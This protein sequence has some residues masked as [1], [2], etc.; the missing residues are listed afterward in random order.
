M[1]AI[2][3]CLLGIN[4]RYNGS[5]SLR[6]TFLKRKTFYLP[7]CPEQLGGMPTPRNPAEIQGLN[8]ADVIEGKGRVIDNT[9]ADVT[10]YFLKGAQEVLNII[11]MFDIKRIYLKDGSPSCGVNIIKKNGNAAEGMGVTTA[12]ISR[13]NIEVT[14]IR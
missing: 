8:G 13:E 10:D 5:N 2:S 14:G 4:C 3:A 11:R 7:L 12:L 1:I 6:K 9:G